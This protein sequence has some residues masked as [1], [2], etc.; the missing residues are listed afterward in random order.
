VNGIDN[1]VDVAERLKILKDLY[2]NASLQ[3]AN[4]LE[5]FKIVQIQ[6]I[7]YIVYTAAC[8][9]E[10]NDP[11]PG[12]GIAWE[13]VPGKGMTIGSELQIAET[14]AWGRAIVAAIQTSTKRIAT[15]EDVA[16][17]KHRQTAWSVEPK[18][19]VILEEFKKPTVWPADQI[20]SK[21]M[22][23]ADRV[24]NAQP[25][26]VATLEVEQPMAVNE[27]M[28]SL[29]ATIID[30]EEACEHGAM[31]EISGISQKTNR[32]YK[33]YKCPSGVC[34]ARFFRNTKAGWVKGW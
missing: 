30:A 33:G 28:D 13:R 6:D 15:K 19:E 12:I 8:Y 32:P 27:I 2:P 11:R 22:E 1:Y 3:P 23:A 17:A 34:N 10:P 20:E 5:P 31:V 7:T 29:N 25:A 4:I 24:K 14:S 9:R 21:V 18:T 16:H 26:K